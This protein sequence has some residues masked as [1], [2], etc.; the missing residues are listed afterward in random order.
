M[1]LTKVTWNMVDQVSTVDANNNQYFGPDTLA[2]L[3]SGI[4]NLAIGEKALN[5]LTSS[6]WN[7]AVG[8]EAL[9]TCTGEN[10]TALGDLAMSLSTTG[11]ANVALGRKALWFNK[12]GSFNVATGYGAMLWSDSGIN[13]VAS[14]LQALY[15]NRT[16]D[17]NVCAGRN[18][19]YSNTSGSDNIGLGHQALLYGNGSNN[20]AIGKFALENYGLRYVAGTF[21][22][23]N[24]YVIA[25]LGNTDFTL[26]GASQ[27]DPGVIF[28]ATGV[29]TGTGVA[30]LNSSIASNNVAIGENAMRLNNDG[31]NNT[32]VGS[33]AL[34]DNT[35]G[36]GN[37]AFGTGALTVNT[38]GNDNVS[39]GNSSLY[40]NLTGSN[41][42]ACGATALFNNVSGSGNI[43]FGG[44]NAGGTYAPVFD[45]TTE[46]N[47]V[48]MGTTAVTNAYVQ[49]AWTV[50]SD[51]RDKTDVEDSPYGLSFVNSLRPIIY[52]RDDRDRYKETD[53]K[54]NITEFP[55]DGSRKDEKYTMGF[56]AQEIIEAEKAA[57]AEDGKFLIADDEIANKLK[58]TETKIIPALVKA[59]QELKSEFDAYKASHP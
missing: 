10:N 40:K 33:Q 22:I 39:L 35:D 30:A 46:S 12:S 6:S 8:W 54:G 59:I 15:S 16:G 57:G 21:I 37:A 20:V 44:F 11:N 56:L 38:T 53:S 3:T 2:S 36:D 45:V 17:N 14:G 7:T 26:I 47:R 29:G 58:I 48:V 28:I 27:N 1:A 19:I 50:V 32:A 9:K 43:G 42:T 34:T 52:K 55:K 49:V 18:S 31:A 23:G 41:N 51:A 24:E 13:N 4:R 5:S 25:E